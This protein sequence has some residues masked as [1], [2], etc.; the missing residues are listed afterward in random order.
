MGVTTSSKDESKR[1]ALMVKTFDAN[2]NGV[3]D[4]KE[5]DKLVALMENEGV[6]K[7]L[8]QKIKGNDGFRGE[9]VEPLKDLDEFVTWAKIQ[10]YKKSLEEKK[11]T[12]KTILALDSEKD[13]DAFGDSVGMKPGHLARLRRCVIKA[14]AA[15]AA[16]GLDVSGDGMIDKEEI[17]SFLENSK[18]SDDDLKKIDAAVVAGAKKHKATQKS[19]LGERKRNSADD[20]PLPMSRDPSLAPSGEPFEPLDDVPDYLDFKGG[21]YRRPSRGGY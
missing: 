19:K 15:I 1:A 6:S 9:A 5:L 17:A 16:A 4:K 3:I 11:V 20:E 7:E 18:I 14:N 21:S 13:F 8:I 12:L 2:V 10:D